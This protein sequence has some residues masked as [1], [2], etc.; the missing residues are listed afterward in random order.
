MHTNESSEFVWSDAWLILSIAMADNGSGAT[1]EAILSAG[2]YINHAIF[3]G[4]ELRHGM[5]HL[6][7]AGYVNDKEGRFF[8][9]G[10]AKDYWELR[11]QTR[12][13]INTLLKN[14]EKF[15]G[16]VPVSFQSIA[17]EEQYG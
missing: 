9:S 13:S 4:L 14:F 16:A 5:A 12:C 11:R 10:E 7:R 2:D 8:L 6:T 3:T 17:A 15:L 1:L